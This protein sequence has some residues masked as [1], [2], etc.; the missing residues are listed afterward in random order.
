MKKDNWKIKSLGEV[1]DLMATGKTPST[2]I[3]EYFEKEINWFTPGDIGAS[4]DLLSSSRYI[5]LKAITDKKAIL[6]PEE[7]LLIT[8]IGDIGRAGILKKPASSN[9]QITGIK[10]KDD[11]DIN[12]G[13]Y[14]FI[15]NSDKLNHHANSAVVPILNNGTLKQINFSY[16]DIK[17]QQKISSILEQADAARQKR[18]Q[19]TQLTEQFLQSVFLDMFGDPVRNEKGWEKD[20][21]ENVVTN[22]NSKRVPVK[23]ADRDLRQGIYPYYGATGIIDTI[24]DY[25][26]DGEYLLIAE[27]GKNL[28][29]RRK[30]NA[31]VARGKF[32]VN[33]HAHVLSFNGRA[34]LNYLLF[35]LNQTD[36]K[37]FITGID[38]FK[39]NKDNLDRIPILLPPLPL[40]QK[41]ASIV[42]Q[43]E[44]LRVKQRESEREL[45]NL[46]QSLM[47]RYFGYD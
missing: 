34:N 18:K 37:P 42:E 8:C 32:W 4:K 16:P 15:Y 7:T 11:V 40:Q 36:L 38:Q 2:L 20:T 6:F 25:K 3:P 13:Y 35:F 31:F 39:L 45:E 46:F 5:S 28:L 33:N 47:Q 29:F 43:V 19:A 17:T 14:W 24:D 1:V 9:Q 22:E 30:N 41:F 23:Q 26:F 44:Q 10:F 21:L 27:D 12:Y